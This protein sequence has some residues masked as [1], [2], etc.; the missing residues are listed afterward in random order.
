MQQTKQ[1]SR[2]YTYRIASV[3]T[4]GGC[5]LDLILPSSTVRL[6]FS[7]S[8]LAGMTGKTELAVSRL[9][10]GCILG[11]SIASI[12]ND[13]YGPSVCPITFRSDFRT[14]LSCCDRLDWPNR[15]EAI[16]DGCLCKDGN[17]PSDHGVFVPIAKAIRCSNLGLD[18]VLCC[19]FCCWAWAGSVGR[20]L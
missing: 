3:T 20:Y 8:S 7:S 17:M 15:S 9:L 4:L 11:S 2:T 14:V 13:K 16:I 19:R 10:A 6:S 5:S 1:L 18:S 12:L